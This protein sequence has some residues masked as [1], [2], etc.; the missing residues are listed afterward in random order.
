MNVGVEWRHLLCVISS[1]F[2]SPCTCVHTHAP[3]PHGMQ[4][5]QGRDEAEQKHMSV[6]EVSKL[7]EEL[8]RIH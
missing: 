2:L 8:A 7:I 5:V 1:F 4:L 6:D 3:L